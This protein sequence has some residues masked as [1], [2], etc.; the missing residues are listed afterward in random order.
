MP[1]P[2]D[3]NALGQKDASELGSLLQ[4]CPEIEPSATGM[5]NS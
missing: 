4:H 1:E 3:L 5:G 2:F